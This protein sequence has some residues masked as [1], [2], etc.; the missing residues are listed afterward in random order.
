MTTRDQ[1]KVGDRAEFRK[2]MTAFEVREMYQAT[3]V[4]LIKANMEDVAVKPAT[5][6]GEEGFRLEFTFRTQSGLIRRGFAVG[7]IYR[8]KLYMITYTAPAMHYYD[9]LAAD[10]ENLLSSIKKI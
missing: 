3:M 2:T 4:T 1:P 5:F 9:A 8:D 10:A 6:G 7:A